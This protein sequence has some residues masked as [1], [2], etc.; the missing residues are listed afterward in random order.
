MKKAIDTDTLTAIANAIRTK[1]ETTE[2]IKV[3]DFASRILELGKGLNFGDLEFNCG[4]IEHDTHVEAKNAPIY[5][6]LSDIPYFS[7][8]ISIEDYETLINKCAANNINI[9]ANAKSS[10]NPGK[11]PYAPTYMTIKKDGTAYSGVN[12]SYFS[13]DEEKIGVKQSGIYYWGRYFWLAI[14]GPYPELLATQDL[15]VEN[16]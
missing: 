10:A 14:T 4:Y 13:H 7:I 15:E 11:S 6:G 1:D 8:I 9:L 5:H 12:N 16:E 2:P 3:E